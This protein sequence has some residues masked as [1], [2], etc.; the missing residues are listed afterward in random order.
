MIGLLT[1]PILEYYSIKFLRLKNCI[2]NY[3]K[4]VSVKDGYHPDLLI[5]REANFIKKIKK[6]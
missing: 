3:E 2:I 5:S 1:H 4:E 6:S